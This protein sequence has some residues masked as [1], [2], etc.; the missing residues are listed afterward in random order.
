MIRLIRRCQSQVLIPVSFP[1]KIAAV[2]NTAAHTH[3]M[4]VH[5]LGGGMSHNISPPLKGTAVNGRG[6]RII[7]NER[8]PMAVSQPGK[9]LNV[10]YHQR[11]IGNGLSENRAGIR[12]KRLGD[13]LLRLVRIHQGTLNPKPF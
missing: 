2:H 4:S 7:H 6:K 13:L 1:V 10:Q 8:H 5:I 11:R 9:L 12:F 3:G